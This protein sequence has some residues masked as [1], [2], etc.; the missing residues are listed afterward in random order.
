M[1]APAATRGAAVHAG[2]IPAT[3]ADDYVARLWGEVLGDLEIHDGFALAEDR[4]IAWAVRQNVPGLAQ[5]VDAWVRANRKGTLLGNILIKRYLKS[6]DYVRRALDGESNERLLEMLALFRKYGEQYDLDPLLMAAQGYQESGLD[7]SVVS[8]VGAIGV[9]QVLPSTAADKAVGI[10]DISTVEN[11]IHA[12]TK[13]VRHL[14][15]VYFD[16][17]DVDPLN[18]ALFAFAGY[19]AG[20]NRVQRLRAEAAEQGF[21]PN[22]WFGNVERVVANRV[23]IEPVR[24]VGN[25][26]KYYTAYSLVDWQHRLRGAS[27]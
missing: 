9:M 3:V 19:N 27:G 7:Q 25:I 6:Q 14:I 2:L 26:F 5:R 11:N 20:P 16:D 4:Q 23:G 22:V 12:G 8:A 10:P 13:Y 1:S 18:R 17:P 21:D 15:D 24:Y